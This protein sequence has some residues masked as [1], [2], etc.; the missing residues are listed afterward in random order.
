MDLKQLIGLH[1]LAKT[2]ARKYPRRRFVYETLT[3]SHSGKHFTGVLGPRGAG[4]TVILR[5]YALDNDNAF[6]L[7]ADALDIEDDPWTLIRTLSEKMSFSTFLLDEIHFLPD[8]AGL[9]KRL[10]DFLDIR[11]LFTSSV[12]LSMHASAHDLSRRVK[13]MNIHPF[14]YREYLAF[15]KSVTIPRLT[16]PALIQRQWTPEHLRSGYLFDEYLK[17]GLL[18]FSLDEPAPLD[19]L[20]NILEKV[21]MK[22]IPSVLRLRVDELDTIKRLLRFI[23][24]SNVDGINYSTLSRNLGITKYKAEQYVSCLEKAFVLHSVFPAGTNVLREPK[25]LMAPPYRLLYRNYQDAVGGLREDFFAECMK[26]AGVPFQYLKSTQGSKTPDFLIEG[27]EKLAIEI[28]GKGKGREQFK[29][30]T[31]N[32]KLIFAHTAEPDAKRLPLFMLGYLT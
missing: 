20:Q 2:D 17:G 10:Y 13:M 18:P 21:I 23:G 8:S 28:G 32:R 4:K 25:I 30:I 26:Q 22:D 31:V 19:L 1:E 9:L 12:A 24:L 5:Q 15:T 6:Y 16:L 11:V 29:G 27:P 14:S 3:A 7:S